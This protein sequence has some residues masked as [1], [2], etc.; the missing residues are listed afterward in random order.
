MQEYRDFHDPT[1]IS[2]CRLKDGAQV[3]KNLI[4]LLPNSALN[5]D[6]CFRIEA[7]LT[8][9]EDKVSSESPESKVL[10]IA[11]R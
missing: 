11:E 7:A 1:E 8:R 9:A 2:S 10:W 6:S 3:T 5:Q 4:G